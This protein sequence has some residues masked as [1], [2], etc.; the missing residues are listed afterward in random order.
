RENERAD[1]DP[2]ELHVCPILDEVCQL[3][4]YE[5]LFLTGWS[6]IIEIRNIAT[7]QECVTNCAAVMHAGHCAAIYFIHQSCFLLE[8]MTHLQNH[9]IRENDSVFAEL[10]FCEPNIRYTLSA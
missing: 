3:E 5:P 7:L 4:F 2:P 9:F 10:L 6:V 8:R 1:N